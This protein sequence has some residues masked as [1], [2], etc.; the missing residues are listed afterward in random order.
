MSPQGPKLSFEE[1]LQREAAEETAEE[2]RKLDKA[3][4]VA[5]A[6]GDT[7]AINKLLPVRPTRGDVLERRSTCS[8]LPQHEHEGPEYYSPAHSRKQ[9][10]NRSVLD[11]RKQRPSTAPET[12][13]DAERRAVL[14]RFLKSPAS[15]EMHRR[16]LKGIRLYCE[17]NSPETVAGVLRTHRT[18]VNRWLLKAEKLAKA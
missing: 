17:N 7:K 2:Q 4:G 11:S 8:L 9:K 16:E 13:D 18:T 10:G 14:L 12:V 1:R 5:I 6:A 15:K 3:L